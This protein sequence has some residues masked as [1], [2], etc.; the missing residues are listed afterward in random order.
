MEF[1]L[2]AAQVFFSPTML[3]VCLV[4]GLAGVIFGAIPGLSGGTC[5]ILALPITYAMDTNMA[6]ALLTSI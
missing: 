6:V 1:M 5:M 3:L 2:D 4:G